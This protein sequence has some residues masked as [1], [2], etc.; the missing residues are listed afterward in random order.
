LQ[1]L[2]ESDNNNNI[3]EAQIEFYKKT[4]EYFQNN[5]SGYAMLFTGTGKTGCIL[6][7]VASSILHPDLVGNHKFLITA[8]SED[9]R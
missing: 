2:T 1:K 9:G 7:C 6:M 3:R 4:D 5:S 8:P